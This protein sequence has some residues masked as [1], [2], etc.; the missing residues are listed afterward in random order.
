MKIRG[1]MVYLAI[2]ALLLVSG[3]TEAPNQLSREMNNSDNLTSA[4]N[5][6]SNALY[7]VSTIDALLQGV[8]DGVLPIGE[9]KTHGDFGL[10]TLDGLDGEMLALDGNYYQ[11]KT[12]GIAYVVPDNMTT[13]FTAVTFFKADKTYRLEKP[14]NLTELEHYLD[15]NLPSNNFIYAIR[16]D[17]NFSYLKARSVPKQNKP[18]PKLVNVVANQSTFEFKNVSGTLVGFKT[19]SYMSDIN[20]AGYHLHFI[21]TNRSAGGHVLDLEVENGTAAIDTITVFLMELPT[22]SDFSKVELGQNLKA[23]VKTVE[24]NVS[25]PTAQYVSVATAH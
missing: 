22:S 18:Y 5:L 6:G 3:C 14:M 21:N 13:P 20:V 24:S 25:V 12:N 16:V 9:L 11:V 1:Y 19:P 23:D 2:L 17:G 7:Q 10:G 4:A 15:L 8:Y